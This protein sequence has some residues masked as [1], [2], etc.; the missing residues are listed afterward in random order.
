MIRS[1]ENL[2]T[3]GQT[4]GQT[5]RQ[6]DKSDFIERCTNNVELPKYEKGKEWIQKKYQ[7]AIKKFSIYKIK[8]K[9]ATKN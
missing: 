5:D 4:D 7:N 2:M 3:D 1:W 6:A 8:Q 9:Q